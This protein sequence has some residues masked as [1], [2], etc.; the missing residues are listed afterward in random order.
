MSE[1][2]RDN[3]SISSRCSSSLSMR[4]STPLEPIPTTPRSNLGNTTKVLPPI[5]LCEKDRTILREITDFIEQELS[6]IDIKN[7][8]QVYVIYKDAFDKVLK[9]I[10][11]YS[12]NIL[13]IY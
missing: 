5:I 1:Y 11:Y 10:N 7:T 6:Y 3:V 13:Y 9:I 2:S 12:T 4:S 8:E